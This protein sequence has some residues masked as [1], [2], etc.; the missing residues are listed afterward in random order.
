MKA[1]PT[2]ASQ[3]PQSRQ[4]SLADLIQQDQSDERLA[5]RHSALREKALV[6]ALAQ[7]RKV[8]EQYDLGAA[9]TIT[10]W[11]TASV[12]PLSGEPINLVVGTPCVFGSRCVHRAD[13]A[14]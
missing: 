14:A 11:L 9:I 5:A 10:D 13:G 4:N 3:S 12:A 6:T 7:V 8:V 2:V 1:G